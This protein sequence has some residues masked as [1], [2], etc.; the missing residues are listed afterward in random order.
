MSGVARLNWL[1]I[2]IAVIAAEAL[3]ILLLVLVVVVYGL[4]RQAD[5]PTPEEFA[6]V[7]GNW[8]GPIGGFVATLLLAWR[9]ARRAL[10]RPIAHGVAVGVGTAMLDLALAA[11]LSGSVAVE[12]LL[13]VSNGGRIRAKG[14]PDR[15]WGVAYDRTNHPPN[16]GT[17]YDRRRNHERAED[18][19]H[20]CVQKDSAQSRR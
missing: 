15:R 9:V 19:G 20:G 14:R 5:S 17:K 11:L 1:R 7:A 16:R 12:A 18:A 2:I 4:I 13:F 10:E 6:P 8:V 3:P